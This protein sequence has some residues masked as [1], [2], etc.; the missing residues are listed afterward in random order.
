MASNGYNEANRTWF[1]ATN[2]ESKTMVIHTEILPRTGFDWVAGGSQEQC[3]IWSV[4]LCIVSNACC[5]R[6][7]PLRSCF[8]QAAHI[9]EGSQQQ[10]QVMSEVLEVWRAMWSFSCHMSLMCCG[11]IYLS[12]L[13]C[14]DTNTH[15]LVNCLILIIEIP[16][17]PLAVSWESSIFLVTC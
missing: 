5:Y 16:V 2:E 4:F 12:N 1:D 11:A 10:T 14:F 15:L 3:Q 9:A 8:S 7:D 13:I 17:K 6:L